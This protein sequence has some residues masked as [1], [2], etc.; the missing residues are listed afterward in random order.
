MLNFAGI[1][2]S[3]TID[4]PGKIVAV[5]YLCGCDF[6]CPFCHNKDIVLDPESCKK[7]EAEEII[8]QLKENFLI[9]GVCITGGEPLLQEEAIDFIKAL[10]NTKLLVKLDTNMSYPDRL[11]SVIN[12]LDFIAVDIK[13]PIEKYGL[14]IGLSDA[15]KIVES[16]RKSLEILKSSKVPKE[17]RTTIV[18]GINDTE[19][20]I[21]EIAKIVA[22]T[23]FDVYSLQQFRPKNTLDPE[24]EDKPSPSTELM[25]NLGKV[26]KK[27]LPNSRV[28]VATM[29]HGFQD[30][31]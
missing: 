13:A 17:A 9:E 3:S 10:K 14:A 25:Q 31:P 30:V 24:Y 15:N 2:D 27:Y 21:A 7:L 11:A 18:P 6:R 16:L 26:A 12:H 28:R 23:G 1:V 8:R 4:Y 29:E 20:D 19:E 5:V 22:D